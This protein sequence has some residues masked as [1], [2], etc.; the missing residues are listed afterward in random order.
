[1][2][3]YFE[4]G[5]FYAVVRSVDSLILSPSAGIYITIHIGT[6]VYSS[7]HYSPGGQKVVYVHADVELAGVVFPVF[8][9]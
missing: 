5:V 7:K 9:Q 8:T 6:I 2:P 3:L 1:M 4:F